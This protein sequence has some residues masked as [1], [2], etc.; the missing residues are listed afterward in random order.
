[1]S[2]IPSTS[3][4]INP[5][6][7]ETIAGRIPDV[8]YMMAPAG[9]GGEKL[10]DILMPV[11]DNNSNCVMQSKVFSRRTSFEKE[12]G[13]AIDGSWASIYA[14]WIYDL[15]SYTIRC[16]RVLG[17]NVA[18]ATA[19]IKD[20]QNTS[21]LNVRSFGQS[22]YYNNT[23]IDVDSSTNREAYL[24]KANASFSTVDGRLSLS[25]V[26]TA[27]N[28]L[29]FDGKRGLTAAGDDFRVAFFGDGATTNFDL[30]GFGE[31]DSVAHIPFIITDG[32]TTFEYAANPVDVTAGSDLFSYN[33]VTK[34]LTFGRAPCAGYF[35][36][37]IKGSTTT[38]EIDLTMHGDGTKT[39]FSID[40][41]PYASIQF[42]ALYVDGIGYQFDEKDIK[43]VRLYTESQYVA[44]KGMKL[45]VSPGS[46]GAGYS[47][48]ELVNGRGANLRNEK[49]D[50]MMTLKDIVESIN[51]KS[52]LVRAEGMV[53]ETSQIPSPCAQHDF[54]SIGV[55]LTIR[56]ETA[57]GQIVEKYDDM[58]DA[59]AIVQ[60]VNGGAYGSQLV[61]MEVIGA[62]GASKP[63]V[64]NVASEN[65][66]VQLTGGAAGQDVDT[67]DY[68]DA[69]A[70]AETA[71][72]VTIVI[73]PG[74]SDSAFH[75]LMNSHCS[76][77]SKR[78]FYRTCAVGG[79]GA[80]DGTSLTSKWAVETI[81][82]KI[83][84]TRMLNS[85]RVCMMGSGVAMID[86]RVTTL[87][88]G[89]NLRTV[90]KTVFPP[91]VAVVPF[92]AQ[93][94]SQPFWVCHTYKYLVNVYGLD[95]EYDE[96]QH[97]ELHAARI[98]TFR[99]NQGVQIVDAI[100]TS[101]WN[102]YEDIHSVRTFDVVS[103]GVNKAMQ[104]AI[105][106][107]NMP[108]TWAYVTGLIRRFLESLRNTNAIMDFSILNETVP[109]DLVDRRF[110]F[111]IGL[112]PVF[113]IKYVEGEIDIMPPMSLPGVG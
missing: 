12:F 22:E 62:N 103:R 80:Y 55:M 72:D 21:I 19:T 84:R 54:V 33:S 40:F 74:V 30:F 61:V 18:F 88:R 32:Q 59:D 38:S 94:I 110:K 70:E 98:V 35:N 17:P 47:K 100:T 73:A 76:T 60:K 41:A 28:R 49:Y 7:V 95:V 63:M 90:Q 51:S 71:L 15:G 108:P 66:T 82:Q 34:Q 102:A 109:Q 1:M 69:L 57:G 52:L 3:L 58:R 87:A 36:L 16:R 106:K 92:V 11:L 13:R 97:Q 37:V 5:E 111:R 8:V 4:V 6:G 96:A 65:I 81:E 26:Y 45:T 56:N 104:M 107:S 112:I 27:T 43:L 25:T 44:L 31:I 83:L 10:N 86:P 9:K 48:I 50:N 99:I 39:V 2:N 64:S 29:I 14:T 101:V 85:E 89:T 46:N 75:D 113:P 79:A 78:G 67:I 42:H 68:L 77:M 24:T 105:G 53:A 23:Y 93:V 20:D 91:S